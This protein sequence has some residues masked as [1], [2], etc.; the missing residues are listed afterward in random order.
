[1]DPRIGIPVGGCA[2]EIISYVLSRP[3]KFT[4]LSDQTSGSKHGQWATK[5]NGNAIRRF[6]KVFIKSYRGI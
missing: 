1:M 4:P 3:D 6:M 2:G 5:H